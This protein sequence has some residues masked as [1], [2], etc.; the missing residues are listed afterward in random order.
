MSLRN[1]PDGLNRKSSQACRRLTKLHHTTTTALARLCA[2]LFQV[3]LVLCQLPAFWLPLDIRQGE[4][5]G[6]VALPVWV[7]W[8]ESIEEHVTQV[9]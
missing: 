4:P 1:K 9:G 8:L 5:V 2:R 6:S 3:D 7:V